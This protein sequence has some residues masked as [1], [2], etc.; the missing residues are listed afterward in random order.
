MKITKIIMGM[1]ITIEIVDRVKEDDIKSVFDYFIHVDKIFSTYKKTSEI[2]RINREELKKKDW[3][4][5]MQQVI[6]L[7]EETKKLTNG[8]FDI[9]RNGKLEPAGLVKGWAIQNAADLLKDKGYRNFYIDA[10]GDIQLSGENKKGNTWRIGIRNPFNQKQ[11]IKVILARDKG[12][13]TSGTYI[14]GYHIYNP[15]N[16]LASN[17]IVSITVIGPNIYEADRFATAAFA[18]GE[19][20]ISFISSLSGFEGYMVDKGGMATYTKGFSKYVQNHKRN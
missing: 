16:A 13:A 17:N 6:R 2:S 12:I 15:H 5:E 4:L 14:R 9:L 8:Y 11:I 19:R 7:C 18:M 20:G 1:P 3:S 10:G